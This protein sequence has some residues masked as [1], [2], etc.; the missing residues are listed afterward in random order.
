MTKIIE[1]TARKTVFAELKH[2]DTLAKK[3]DF[4]EVTEWSNVDGFDVEIVSGNMTSR[5]QLTWEQYKA[6][7]SLV[8][9]L[10]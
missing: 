9:E 2:Y 5:F 6:L 10:K 1:T 8:K 4:I 7:K 3:E